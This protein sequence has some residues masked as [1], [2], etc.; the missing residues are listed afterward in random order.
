MGITDEDRQKGR[1]I[2]GRG[3][4]HIY[5]YT[6]YTAEV[7]R[8]DMCL[9]EEKQNSPALPHARAPFKSSWLPSSLQVERPFLSFFL[10]FF[11]FFFTF[12]YVLVFN[13]FL[14]LS[15]VISL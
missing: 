11:S 8:K 5:I 12:I 9:L 1:H 4:H 7:S 6:R 2:G 13:L 15:V 3:G 14:F 10:S